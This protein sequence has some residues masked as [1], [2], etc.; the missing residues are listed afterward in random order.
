MNFDSRVFIPTLMEKK[1]PEPSQ[2]DIA[3]LS[4]HPAPLCSVGVRPFE[5]RMKYQIK[6]LFWHPWLSDSGSPALFW[7]QLGRSQLLCG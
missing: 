3:F 2:F 1:K 6:T 4:P 5:K 7:E